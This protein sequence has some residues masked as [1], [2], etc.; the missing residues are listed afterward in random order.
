MVPKPS[1]SDRIIMSP[2]Q[3]SDEILTLASEC[4]KAIKVTQRS[5]SNAYRVFSHEEIIAPKQC[6]HVI[7][8]V[9]RMRELAA[10][11][12][13]L[14]DKEIQLPE[15]VAPFR[16]Q[17]M[18]ELHNFDI[19]ADEVRSRITTFRENL[20]IFSTEEVTR[21]LPDVLDQIVLFKQRLDAVNCLLGKSFGKLIEH[22]QSKDE[23]RCV[24]RTKNSRPDTKSLTTQQQSLDQS[25]TRPLKKARM[26]DLKTKEDEISS[27][28]R[29]LEI[30]KGNLLVVQEKKVEYI[31]PRS[32]PPDLE[33]SEK[34][35]LEEIARVRSRLEELEA[36]G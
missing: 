27:L 31:D 29:Q 33:K 19:Q 23:L 6:A 28:R 15:P 30:L 8:S 36:T 25:P 12:Y 22:S 20:L 21:Q 7:N 3:K 32:V 14:L 26:P 10:K 11:L 34:L 5:V 18:I 35:T 17:L 1:D 16:L 2:P 9:C 24:V 13:E 4:H